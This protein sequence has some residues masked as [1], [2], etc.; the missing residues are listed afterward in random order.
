[1]Q[2]GENGDNWENSISFPLAYNHIPV[3]IMQRLSF[4]LEHT[5]VI[6]EVYV[7]YFYYQI[8][9]INQNTANQNV[10]WISIGY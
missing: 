10:F 1:L 8:R 7:N 9:G 2:W 6:Q 4:T 3:I 5:P